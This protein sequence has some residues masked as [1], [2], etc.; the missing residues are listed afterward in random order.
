MATLWFKTSLVESSDAAPQVTTEMFDAVL[1]VKPRSPV[2]FDNRLR[3][4]ATFLTLPEA[5]SLAAANKRTA[6]ILRKAPGT[7]DGAVDTS[8][9]R[10]PAEVQLHAAIESLKEEVTRAV[11]NHDYGSALTALSRLKPPVDAFFDQVLVMDP[12]ES[13]RTNR[14]ALLAMLRGLFGGIADLSRLPG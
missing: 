9:L 12:D 8:R 11:A 3:A 10:E 4:L 5:A 1:S 2:D 7:V 14:L 13:L 6:N